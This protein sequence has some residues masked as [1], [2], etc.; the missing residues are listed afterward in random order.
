MPGGNATTG[1]GHPNSPNDIATST[2]PYD[3]NI[4]PNRS[5]MCYPWHQ[6]RSLGTVE[7]EYQSWSY[8]G[9]GRYSCSSFM[10]F[11]NIYVTGFAKNRPNSHKN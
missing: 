4:T 5:R 8:P 6:G 2:G 3:V 7:E 1:H 9:Q 11:K 10:Y